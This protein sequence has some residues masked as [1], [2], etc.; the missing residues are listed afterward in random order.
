[1]PG[2]LATV[3]CFIDAL[4]AAAEPVS[5]EV[6]REAA[7][8]ARHWRAHRLLDALVIATTAVVSAD[9]VGL[10]WPPPSLAG[11]GPT[12]GH[13]KSWEVTTDFTRWRSAAPAVRDE[14]TLGAGLDD[15]VGLVGARGEVAVLPN[16]RAA[17]ARSRLRWARTS[18][19]AT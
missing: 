9:K 8:R 4:P 14:V 6:A 16:C 13:P 17:R 7:L 10:R 12:K 5:R 1:V 11:Q 3:D 2:T 15:E 19:S 18:P